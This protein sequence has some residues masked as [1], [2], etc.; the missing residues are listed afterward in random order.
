VGDVTN[1][2]LVYWNRKSFDAIRSAAR[3]KNL[4]TFAWRIILN[5]RSFKKIRRI[6]IPDTR[7]SGCFLT[8]TKNP[9]ET[10]SEKGNVKIWRKT[11]R[12]Q[13]I[14]RIGS[15]G[16]IRTTNPPVNSRMLCR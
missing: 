10:G 9:H 15:S 13:G 12:P 4:A 1:G 7:A 2:W 11:R 14:E 8:R 3:M 16:W 5:L 6:V